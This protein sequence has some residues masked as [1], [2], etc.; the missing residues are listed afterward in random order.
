MYPCLGSIL[1]WREVAIIIRGVAFAKSSLNYDGVGRVFL[2]DGSFFGGE[3]GAGEN[4]RVV[5]D[6]PG[7]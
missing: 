2:V 6:I 3:L 7:E 1:R 5:H 4:G